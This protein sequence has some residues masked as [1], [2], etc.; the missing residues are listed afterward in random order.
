[1]ANF[2]MNQNGPWGW[3]HGVF[4]PADS[5]GLF[6]GAFFG[7]FMLALVIW[8]VYWKYH[9]IWHAVKHEHKWW[10]LA[11]LLINTAGIL[12]I[13]YLYIF[14]KKMENPPHDESKTPMVTP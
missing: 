1:M 12:E 2:Y 9:A 7:L 10:F 11:L 13:L 5:F 3:N 14:S 4:G 8:T 6:M